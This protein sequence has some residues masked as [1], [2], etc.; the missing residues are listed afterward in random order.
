MSSDLL[1]W[2]ESPPRRPGID[3]V[4]GGQKVNGV[5]APDPVRML[6]AEDCNQTAAQ[7]AAMGRVVGVCKISVRFSG[8]TPVLYK[9]SAP[10]SDVE[11][12]TFTI[13]DNGTGD[14]SITWPANTFP[15]LVVEA[16]AFVNGA[17]PAMIAA[18]SITNG[19][20]VRTKSD[21][22]V[23]NDIAFTCTVN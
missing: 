8:G 23:A 19:V 12:A 22:G 4:G 20:R 5:P 14:T 21:A 10:G 6:T 3:D 2:D 1:T 16:E 18:E 15:T 17:T 13:T 11:T 9:F 7:I